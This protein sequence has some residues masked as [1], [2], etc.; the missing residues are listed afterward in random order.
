MVT[1]EAPQRL[2]L[3][4]PV[5][6]VWGYVAIALF[7]T[8]DGIE[9]AFLSHYIVD[10]GFSPTQASFL[11]TVYGLLAALSSWSSGV[12][13][14]TFGPRRIMLIGVAAWLVFHA[15]F[16]TFGLSAQNYPL[17][18]L[19]YGIRG[20]AYP[21]F[22][23]AF[24]VWIAQ[25]TPGARLASAMGWY[26]TMYS[27]GIGFLGTYL[28]SLS[29]SRIGF[30]GTLWMA[31]LWVALAA[32]LILFLVKD[33][34]ASGQG[35]PTGLAERLRELRQGITILFVQR[36]ILVTA[37]VRVIC[38][39][40]LFGF[41]VIMPLYLTSADV[42]FT[43]EQWL[44][45]WG[46]MFIV[47]IFTNVIWGWV[48]DRIGWL[49]QMRWFGCVG[50]ALA[51]L[52]FYYLPLMYGA[53]FEIAVVAAVAL[54][55]C[56]SA[57]VPMGAVFLAIS[58]ERKG[59]AISAHNLA[60]GLS[61]FIGPAIATLT[62]SWLGVQ[63]VVWVYASLYLLGAVL[64]CFIRVEQPMLKADVEPVPNFATRTANEST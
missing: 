20:L 34:G 19:F 13:A 38:N 64:T 7:M 5:C 26:W 29:L 21:L 18:V 45:L 51:T 53:H 30:I 25:V 3:G 6:L 49:R 42:G 36:S 50:C 55:I 23:Y 59:A 2:L 60:A 10:L 32:V 35:M 46:V 54:G 4:M 48:G 28:P 41:P 47:T 52:A 22:I 58:P 62:I 33:R 37:I 44:H 56:V 8:G 31:M 40:T 39:L 11:F 61:N 17:M 27:I 24:L 63:G 16:L 43:M 1:R 12:L 14:E 15:L 57:F 9:L